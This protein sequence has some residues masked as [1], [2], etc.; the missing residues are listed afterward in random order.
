MCAP[1]KV[2]LDEAAAAYFEGGNVDAAL[3]RA[4]AAQ[5]GQFDDATQNA[6]SRLDLWLLRQ[7]DANLAR[8][9]WRGRL[10]AILDKFAGG[11]LF[12]GED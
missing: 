7:P 8:K 10:F 11:A 5:V 4:C 6:M 2:I 12:Q 3:A 9:E 1:C